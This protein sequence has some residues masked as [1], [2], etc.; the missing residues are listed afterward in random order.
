MDLYATLLN[1]RGV[2]SKDDSLHFDPSS[3]A[4]ED[5]NVPEEGVTMDDMAAKK[6]FMTCNAYFLAAAIYV[7]MES[8]PRHMYF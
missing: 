7:V 5:V 6:I 4:C 8:P 3:G 1:K 2:D